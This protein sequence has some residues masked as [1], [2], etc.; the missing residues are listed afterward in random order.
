M[1]QLPRIRAGLRQHRIGDQVLIYDTA[2]ERV[3]LLDPTTAFVITL[4]Q[5]GGWTW[6]GVR[7]ELG[8]HL[9]VVPSD[10][11][12]TLALEELRRCELL[13][14]SDAHEPLGDVTRRDMLKRVAIGGAAALLIPTIATL[15][16][17]TAYAVTLLADCAVC[18]ADNQCPS[19]H[20]KDGKSGA[21]KSC[22]IT[23]CL[24]MDVE[25]TGQPN[26]VCCNG[27]CKPPNG[28]GVSVCN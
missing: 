22:V 21:G 9:K 14:P 27:D 1:P 20:C 26:C 13:E 15:T 28:S 10:G 12:L 23:N 11:F 25:C 4:L 19:G 16:A 7:D 2:N 6:E 17:N 24:A 5:A 3:H 8:S 18:T